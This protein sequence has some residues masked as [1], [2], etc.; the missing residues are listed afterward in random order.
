MADVDSRPGDMSPAGVAH[1]GTVT[2]V[3]ITP[4]K[5]HIVSVGSEGAVC[6][7]AYAQPK[8]LADLA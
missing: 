8:A 1:S 4:D 6:I 3:A 2:G 7:W 5:G